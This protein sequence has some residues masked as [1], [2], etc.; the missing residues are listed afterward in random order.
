MVRSS[1]N[2]L[3]LMKCMSVEC[4]YCG[5]ITYLNKY[6]HEYH[7]GSIDNGVKREGEYHLSCPKCHKTHVLTLQIDK[8]KPKT[9]L[10]Y[11]HLCDYCQKEFGSC[12]SHPQFLCDHPQFGLL[13]QINLDPIFND[14]IY[15]CP[16]FVLKKEDSKDD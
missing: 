14:L 11:P 6:I 9:F 1:D 15:L 7:L 13:R 8:E 3:G 2:T 5:H 16:E 12:D 4:L 10:Q